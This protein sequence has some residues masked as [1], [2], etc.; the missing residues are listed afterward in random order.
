[1]LQKKSNNSTDQSIKR[2]V[3]ERVKT[4]SGNIRIHVG[5]N[6]TTL[7]KEEIIKN[8]SN[9]T[10]VGQRLVKQQMAYI[11]ATATGEIYKLLQDE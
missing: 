4:M 5:S 11:Q 1:M 8:I 9:D 10:Q 2:L 7:S 6:Q 3:T